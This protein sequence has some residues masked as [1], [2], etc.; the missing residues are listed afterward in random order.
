MRSTREKTALIAVG[1]SL[2]GSAIWWWLTDFWRYGLSAYLPF[3]A[4]P[5]TIALYWFAR[6]HRLRAQ[7]NLWESVLQSFPNRDFP[8]GELDP[9]RDG[10]GW[11]EAHGGTRLGAVRT[12]PGNDGIHV[13]M[14]LTT[15]R[16]SDKL[17]PWS[18]VAR[19]VHAPERNLRDF[20]DVSLSY[21]S[22][23]FS[24]IRKPGVVIPWRE[25]FDPDVP[26]HVGLQKLP[27]KK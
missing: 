12:L 5:V 24:S 8:G 19:I 22:V 9:K 16:F 20:G 14:A 7:V 27:E 2:L 13:Q 1:L 6:E 23:Q 3:L 10:L 15:D 17:I 26:E 25:T 4:V 11:M 21:A 18:E